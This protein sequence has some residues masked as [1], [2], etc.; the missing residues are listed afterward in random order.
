MLKSCKY[1][2]G[3]HPSKYVCPK[4]PPRSPHKDSKAVLFR[5]KYAWKKKREDIV[6]RD[7]HMCR[8]CNEGS[9]GTFGIPGLNDQP[10]QVHHIEPLEERFDLRLEDD[11]LVTCC[12]GHHKMA[13]AGEIPR[14]YLHELAMTS[15]RWG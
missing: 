11:N 13:E 1:C 9:Y 4:K 3:I 15:P 7:Y 10:L 14:G 2:G 6:R 5:R 12:D 8:V